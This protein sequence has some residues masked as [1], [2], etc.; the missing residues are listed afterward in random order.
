[1][2]SFFVSISLLVA[3]ASAAIVSNQHEARDPG[4]W[5][6]GTQYL[7]PTTQDCSALVRS[8]FSPSDVYNIS[9]SSVT[10]SPNTLILPNTSGIKPV[11]SQQL[12][13]PV[14]VPL[15]PNPLTFLSPITYFP[16]PNPLRTSKLHFQLSRPSQHGGYSISKLQC[17]NS[18]LSLLPL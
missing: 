17:P 1:M 3:L 6:E 16:V 7:G 4:P 15:Y 13:A 8:A 14:Y 10:A 9:Y 12:P 11:A 5:C 2:K 18:P